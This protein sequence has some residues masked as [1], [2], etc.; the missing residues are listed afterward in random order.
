MVVL[1]LSEEKVHGVLPHSLHLQVM[2]Q[3][4]LLL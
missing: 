2:I 4:L 3:I 1:G